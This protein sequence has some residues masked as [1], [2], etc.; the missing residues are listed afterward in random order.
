M[1]KLPVKNIIKVV[2][3]V[4]I[5]VLIAFFSLNYTINNNLSYL[6]GLI[7]EV[8]S[9]YSFSDEVISVNIYGGYYIAVT[10]NE[11]VILDKEYKEVFKESSSKLSKNVNDY[12]LVYRTNK[13]MYEETVVL[14]DVLTYNYYDAYSYEK[15]SSIVLE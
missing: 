13:L 11:V 5:I 4:L 1:K 3:G 12:D 14:D 8:S 9:E 10:A 15:I 6:D 7:K 2:I